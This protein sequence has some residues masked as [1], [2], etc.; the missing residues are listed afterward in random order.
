MARINAGIFLALAISAAAALSFPRYSLAQSQQMK[1]D[2]EQLERWTATPGG[3]FDVNWAA[4]RTI[5]R[6]L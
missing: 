2:I 3:S 1:D 6:R 5:A 4:E